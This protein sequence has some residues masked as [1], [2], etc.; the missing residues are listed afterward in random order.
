MRRIWFLAQHS[1]WALNWAAAGRS[2]MQ[3]RARSVTNTNKPYNTQ[4]YTIYWLHPRDTGLLVQKVVLLNSEDT[5]QSA[6][7]CKVKE[8]S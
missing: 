5:F 7:K 1:E 6:I 2:T 4:K 8:T 3:W